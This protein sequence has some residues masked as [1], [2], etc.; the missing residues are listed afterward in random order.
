MCSKYIRR[1]KCILQHTNA[2]DR[3]IL[4]APDLIWLSRKLYAEC[5]NN[6][7]DLVILKSLSADEMYS[8]NLFSIRTTLIHAL[9]C[10]ER[11][12]CH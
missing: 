1:C 5:M 6:I 12:Q 3:P 9:P 8:D 11:C 10:R 7:K 2:G 4:H